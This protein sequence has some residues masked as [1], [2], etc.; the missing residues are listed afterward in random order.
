MDGT[1][2]LRDRRGDHRTSG[3]LKCLRYT[4]PTHDHITCSTNRR[5]FYFA[6]AF[7]LCST[8]RAQLLPADVGATVAGYQDD[9]DGA[10]LNPNWVVRGA[11][12]YSLN[13]GVLHVA[14]TT[15]DPNHLLYELAGYNNSVQ[16]VLARI[17][18][19]NF[20]SGD[21]PRAGIGAA[22]DPANSQGINLHFRDETVGKHV[23]FLDDARAWGT[24]FVFTWQLNTWY[25]L[26]LRHEPNAASQGG[27]NDVFGKVWLADGSTAEPSNWQFTWDYTPTR[28]ARAGFAG[29]TAGSN[30]TGAIPADFDV[31]YVLIKA[32]GLPN[33]TVAP[34][35]FVQTPVAI[36]NQPQNLTALECTTAS[37]SVIA[38][39]N[40]RPTY[41]W[42]R[43]GT[44]I[45][46]ATNAD[47]AIA[48]AR[49]SDAG[50]Y[51]VIA[52]NFVSN[53]TYSATSS[54]AVLTISADTT[55]PVLLNAQA[56]GLVQVRVTFSERVNGA[57]ANNA[58]NYAL[59]NNTGSITISN[60]L[61]DASGTNVILNVSPLAQNATYTVIVNNITDECTGGNP[62][63]ANSTASFTVTDFTSENVGNAVPAGNHGSHRQR[64]QRD[65]RRQRHR[66]D[67]RSIPIHVA[68]AQRR[69]RRE[70]AYRIAWLVRRVG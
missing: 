8:A 32:S 59:T 5:R 6:A 45:P 63:A 62:I 39:G 13:N 60:A 31:D 66:R 68:T 33:I 15:G 58:S 34:N 67:E 43:N 54:V 57:T 49:P 16:E 22:V 9:F 69:L 44:A 56:L 42:F 26:R 36:T 3:V 1:E 18:L 19:L 20:G 7:Q 51:Y 4:P 40:P 35:A 64:L 11:N 38:S 52:Q 47:Y 29:I 55:R 24:E 41:Q 23:E 48:S 21:P 27:V 30:P 10:A 46:N 25:W 70:S 28:S 2:E 12:V 17:R 61:V 53:T 37:F 50:N 65:R 14:T